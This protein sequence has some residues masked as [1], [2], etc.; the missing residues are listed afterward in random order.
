MRASAHCVCAFYCA[1][2]RTRNDLNIIE[3]AISA[4]AQINPCASIVSYQSN[5]RGVYWQWSW[6]QRV[7]NIEIIIR[8]GLSFCLSQSRRFVCTFRP[9]PMFHILL[10]HSRYASQLSRVFLKCLRFFFL[11]AE[12]HKILE[13]FE[14]IGFSWSFVGK[15][16][17]DTLFDY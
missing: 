14:D 3:W 4:I 17:H 8:W 5:L 10:T 9:T 1:R 7:A 13:E 11:Y 12:Q 6:S 16:M 15:A 2:A